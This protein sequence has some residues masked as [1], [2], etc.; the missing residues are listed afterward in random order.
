M[1]LEDLIGLAERPERMDMG[2]T[3][4]CPSCGANLDPLRLTRYEAPP[5]TLAIQLMRLRLEGGQNGQSRRPGAMP[6]LPAISA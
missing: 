1:D 2:S 4:L 6:A 5:K 3:F